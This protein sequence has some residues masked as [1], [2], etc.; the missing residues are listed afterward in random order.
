MRHLKKG[1]KFHRLRGDR[2][3]FM[4]NLA[5]DLIR[6]GAI[7]TTE[8]RA[9]AIRPTVEKLV[10]FAKRQT[11]PARRII[12][13]RVHN[14]SVAKKLYDVLGPHYAERK[15]GYLRITKLQDS[16]KRDGTR[17]AKIEFV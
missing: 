10:T 16:R 5:N 12:V 17:M 2:I 7:K 6:A 4:R 9:K 14:P 3:S 8:A 15:G 11:L 13:S 1:K